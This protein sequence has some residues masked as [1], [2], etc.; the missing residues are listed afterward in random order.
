MDMLSSDGKNLVAH[1]IS[2]FYNKTHPDYSLSAAVKSGP[3][4]IKLPFYSF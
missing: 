4:F 3:Y 2:H 1:K